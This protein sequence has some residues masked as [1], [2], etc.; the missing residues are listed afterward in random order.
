MEWALTLPEKALAAFK[1]EFG[2]SLDASQL[3]YC[4]K[5]INFSLANLTDKAFIP[6]MK[7]KLTFS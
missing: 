4:V 7:E 2:H 6:K 1:V 3:K 5:E